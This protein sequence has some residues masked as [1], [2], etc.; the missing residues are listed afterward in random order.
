MQ[1]WWKGTTKIVENDREV[2]GVFVTTSWDDGHILDHKL[3]SLLHD[4][5]LRGTFYIAPKN[6]E[7][8]QQL[9]QGK[10]AKAK[11]RSS[12]SSAYPCAVSATH[13]GHTADNIPRWSK[14][15]ALTWLEQSVGE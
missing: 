13:L 15:L 11:T 12:K 8:A 4:Y 2:S 10:S 5:R 3:A 14:T 1:N 6:V 9:R 7:L